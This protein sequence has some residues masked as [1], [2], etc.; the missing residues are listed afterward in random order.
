MP[1]QYTD[2]N[3]QGM[4]AFNQGQQIGDDYVKGQ[5]RNEQRER[6]SMLDAQNEQLAAQKAS[7]RAVKMGQSAELHDQNVEIKQ[8]SINKMEQAKQKQLALAATQM[9]YEERQPFL[10]EI[11]KQTK[12]PI[13]KKNLQ[14]V[15]DMEP[16][17]QGESLWMAAMNDTN[18]S[19]EQKAFESLIAG[20]SP[21]DQV[22]A[23][24]VKA[25]LKGRAMSN[26]VLSAIQSG[27]I[28]N[29]ADAKATIKGAEKFAEMT[30]ISRGKT[31]DK[32][33]LAI[34]NIDK[35]ILN[36]NRALAAVEEGAG[37]GAFEKLFPSIKAASVE[38]DNIRGS[39][40]LDVISGVTL[41]AI[42]APELKLAFDVALPTGL[43]SAELKDHLVRKMAAQTKLRAYF[44]DQ[45]QH[46]DQGG[47]V[48]SF[49]RMKDRVNP[50]QPTAASSSEFAGFKVVR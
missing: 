14:I 41:G 30:A 28:Q 39:M 17:K 16:E 33:F 42:S 29:L 32:G 10:A 9:T 12:D 4:G 49:L 26:A 1:F 18:K 38:L 34:Q 3:S 15:M 5:L 25:G 35:S 19:G 50:Q 47:S 24:K 45:I 31:I 37:V 11:L 23:R 22:T 40:A 6:T 7:D 2:F 20:F 13:I 8:G 46:L 44:N 48:A 36:V 43:D 21:E 27:D